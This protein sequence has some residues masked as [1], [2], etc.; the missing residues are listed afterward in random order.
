MKDQA[1]PRSLK[2][3]IVVIICLTVFVFSLLGASIHN[4]SESTIEEIGTAYG[5]NE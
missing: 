3:S 5:W 1:L 4:M 2:N